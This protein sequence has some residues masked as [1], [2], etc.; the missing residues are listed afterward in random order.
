MDVSRP[1][2]LESLGLPTDGSKSVTHDPRACDE[3]NKA[4]F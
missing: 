2:A 1:A 3:K 4:E